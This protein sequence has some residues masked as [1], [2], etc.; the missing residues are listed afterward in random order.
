MLTGNHVRVVTGG[1]PKR[2]SVATYCK[3]GPEIVF[4]N[5]TEGLL[6]V[7]RQATSG[8]SIVRY[9]WAAGILGMAVVAGLVDGNTGVQE[10]HVGRAVT[11]CMAAGRRA[12]AQAGDRVAAIGGIPDLIVR[13]IRP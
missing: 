8:Q 11:I 13:R 5:R 2:V 7:I 3:G 12:V 1:A 10:L 4:F 6:Y 9:Q